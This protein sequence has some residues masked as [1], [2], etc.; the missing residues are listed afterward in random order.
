MYSRRAALCLLLMALL[1][2]ADGRRRRKWR[3]EPKSDHFDVLIFTQ[4][5][6]QTVCFVWKENSE[7]HIC[8][9]PKG[10][11]WTIHGIWPSQ[12]HKMG[13]QFCNSSL[14]FNR[15]VLRPIEADLREKWVDVQNG[16]EPYSF[17]QHEWEKHGTCAAVLKSLDSEIK[18]FRKGLNLLDI[19][20][21]RDVLAK[22]NIV[23]GKGYYVDDIL[24]GVTKILGK[25]CEVMCVKN[26]KTEVSYVFEIRI[27]FDK[28]LRLIDCDNVYGFPSNCDP[29]EMVIYP[30]SVPH[31]Y[32]VIQ[33]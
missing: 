14:P 18:Y 21:M 9:L 27:C 5:W 13:P 12:Y 25:R 24:R 4:R 3:D 31:D 30:G 6:P 22:V 23:P 11:E 1:I 20:N 29:H 7:T 8:T 15:T 26:P 33:V 28:M 19:Y 2:V 32:R 17:W 16:K 10:D